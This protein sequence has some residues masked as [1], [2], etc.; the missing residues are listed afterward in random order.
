M[1]KFEHFGGSSYSKGTKDWCFLYGGGVGGAYETCNWPMESWRMVIW[2]SPMDR[3]IH[4]T[5]N[6]TV[7]ILL[8]SVLVSI[9]MNAPLHRSRPNFNTSLRVHLSSVHT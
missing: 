7:H 8:G 2:R 6:N 5:E 9:S 1:N 4:T 3:Q